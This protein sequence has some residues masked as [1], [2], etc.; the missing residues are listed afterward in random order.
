M[1]KVTKKCRVCGK[2]YEACRTAQKAV[3]VFHWQEVACSP[4]CG[5]KYLRMVNEARNPAP[6]PKAVSKRSKKSS[7]ASSTPAAA[8]AVALN[9]AD[10]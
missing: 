9:S 7:A 2:E 1:P 4:E 3:G 5:T 6:K 10:E 8:T